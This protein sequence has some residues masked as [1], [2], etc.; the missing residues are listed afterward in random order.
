MIV[1]T[2]LSVVFMIMDHHQYHI[3]WL[4]SGLSVAVAP[5][6]YMVDVPMQFMDWLG[7]NIS[8]QHALLAENTTLR[9]QQLLLQA[10]LQKL[11]ALENENLEL[12]ALLKSSP[13]LGNDRLQVAQLLLVDSEPFVQQVTLNKGSSVGV[14]LN[15]PVLDAYGIVGQIVAVNPLTSSV[16]LITDTRSAVPVQISRSGQRGILIGTGSLGSLELIHVPNNADIRVGDLLVSSGLGERY[17]AG[18]PVGTVSKIVHSTGEHFANITV[19]P[20]AQLNRC[21]Q[22]LLFWSGNAANTTESKKTEKAAKKAV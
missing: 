19:E 16:M 4:R 3:T 2:S 13:R 22:V 14:Y 6:Q 9:A 11:L 5:V 7:S 15:Q 1:L 18:Y 12:R 20:V 10:Q 21:T 8:S 17:P